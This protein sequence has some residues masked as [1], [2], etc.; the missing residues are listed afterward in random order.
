MPQ[1]T[2]VPSAQYQCLGAQQG[3]NILQTLLLQPNQ[4]PPIKLRISAPLAFHHHTELKPIAALCWAD[5]EQN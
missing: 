4:R 5:L 2:E 3:L 1:L